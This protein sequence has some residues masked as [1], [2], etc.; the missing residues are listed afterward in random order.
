MIRVFCGTEPKTMVAC[1]VL[2]HSIRRRTKAAVEFTPMIGPGWEVPKDTPA[3]TGFS[4][5][6]WLIA[7]HCGFLG[8][9][10]YM[11]ADQV[12]LGDVAELAAYPDTAP[13]PGCSA[14]MT[15]QPDKFSNKPWPQSSVMVIDC[16]AAGGQEMWHPH[17]LFNHL[18]GVDRSSRKYAD[19][20]HAT[21]MAPPPARLPDHWNHL[22]VFTEG[23]TRLLHYTKE[24]EQPWYKPDHQLAHVWRKE[25]VDAIKAGAAGT[26]AE[27]QKLLGDWGKK[28]DWRNTNGLHPT[29]KKYLPLF[30]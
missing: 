28:A 13:A 26:R 22:N 8:R 12:V 7:H 14:W 16:E 11:D 25:L 29:Y 18:R 23:V 30:R 2:E 24:P 3:G 6:R 27:F 5:R 9:A 10:I 15:Y 17:K 21:W 4:L 1:R 20:M 19:C